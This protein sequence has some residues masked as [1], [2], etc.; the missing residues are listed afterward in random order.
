MRMGRGRY[1]GFKLY[2]IRFTFGEREGSLN[3][4]LKIKSQSHR[5]K[6]KSFWRCGA[7]I[8]NKK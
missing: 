2:V 3:Q 5:L 7:E 6:F 1:L 8:T 4:R